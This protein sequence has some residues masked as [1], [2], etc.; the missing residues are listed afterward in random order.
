VKGR[1]HNFTIADGGTG[2][3]TARLKAAL[4]DLQQGRAADPHGWL[5]RLV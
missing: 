2:A 4:L 3:L 5:D 1:Q